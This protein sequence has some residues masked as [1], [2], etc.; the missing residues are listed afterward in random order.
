MQSRRL[1]IQ[2]QKKSRKKIQTLPLGCSAYVECAHILNFLLCILF[3]SHLLIDCGAAHISNALKAIRVHSFLCI[4]KHIEL[5]QMGICNL[6]RTLSHTS[7]FDCPDKI[8]C[9]FQLILSFIII[10]IWQLVSNDFRNIFFDIFWS[11]Y[12]HQV[13]Y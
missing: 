1:E 3:L 7:S 5:S 4:E 11:Y 10:F 2:F 8:A 6:I 12:A 13:N 9:G